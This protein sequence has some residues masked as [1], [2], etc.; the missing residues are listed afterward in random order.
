MVQ[1]IKI[2]ENAIHKKLLLDIMKTTI[3]IDLLQVLYL[4]YSFLIKDKRK[5]VITISR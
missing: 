5:N 2:E 3:R 1:N 4:L